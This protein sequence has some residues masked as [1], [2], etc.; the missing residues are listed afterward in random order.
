MAISSPSKVM[1]FDHGSQ[2]TTNAVPT[3]L[4][5]DSPASPSVMPG[6]A[7]ARRMTVLSGLKCLGSFRMSGP[8][9]SSVRTLLES[10]LWGS[11]VCYLTWK[12]SAT[13]QGRLL[14]RL[15]PSTPRTGA[16]G[17]GF[18]PTPRTEGFDAGARRG[19]PDSLHAAEKLWPTPD[20]GMVAGGRSLPDGTSPTGVTPDGRKVQ[21]G[22]TN[23]VKLWPTPHASAHTGAGDH[24]T[25]GPNLQ[26]AVSLL[27]TPTVQDGKNNGGPSQEFRNSQPLNSVIGGKLNPDWVSRM[28]GYPD[29]WMSDLPALGETTGS[30]AS[31]E[32]ATDRLT[33]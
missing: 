21:V 33:A 23:A 6:S 15:V 14:Y 10:S 9:G 17:F 28:M 27:P 22:L 26:T 18:W 16:T 11:T 31:P 32:S 13:P 5:A 8:V 25:G 12:K 29:D 20:A 19:T 7:W 4:R 1:L 3:C 24:G 2:D 30:P